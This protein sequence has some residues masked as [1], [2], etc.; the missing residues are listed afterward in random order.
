MGL[1]TDVAG[2]QQA[3]A[4]GL[5]DPGPR[6]LGIFLLDLEVGDRDVRALPGYAI[7]TARPIPELPPVISAA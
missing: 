6:L 7:A 3:P 1:V 2:E 4:P 5:L